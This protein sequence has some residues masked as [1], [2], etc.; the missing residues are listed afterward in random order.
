MSLIDD[1]RKALQGEKK[2]EFLSQ[3]LKEKALYDALRE[4]GLTVVA[5]DAQARA[6]QRPFGVL[7]KVQKIDLVDLITEITTIKNIESIDLIDAITNISNIAN[8]ANIENIANIAQI[9]S[10]SFESNPIRNGRFRNGFLDWYVTDTNKITIVDDSVYG[11]AVKI[12]Q[13]ATCFLRQHVQVNS[14][15]YD[16]LFLLCKT[17]N[18]ATDLFVV[19]NYTDGSTTSYGASAGVNW[20]SYVATLDSGKNV[21]WITLYATNN[22]YPVYATCIK[23]LSSLKRVVSATDLDIRS[24][25]STSDSVEVKQAT[26]SNLNANVYLYAWDGSAWQKVRCDANGYLITTTPP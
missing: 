11:K 6:L 16:K 13:G 25:V 21:R 10:A 23:F 22:S 4:A 1:I 7:S 9:E 26:P 15:E 14:D 5:E 20:N 17:E 2:S 8:I 3:I 18:A 12:T 19:V 24:L